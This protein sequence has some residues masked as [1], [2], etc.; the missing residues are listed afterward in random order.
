MYS[1]VTDK[2]YIGS[3]QDLE[4]RL[5]RHNSKHM[6]ATKVGA[7]WKIVWCQQFETRAEAYSK[8]MEIKKKKS[9]KYIER[10]IASTN[11]G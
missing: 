8:E 1:E 2:Y 7:P 4:K 9:R 5:F 11:I 6:M 3:T 10:L